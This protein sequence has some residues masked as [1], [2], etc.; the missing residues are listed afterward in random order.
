ML[1]AD[2]PTD[3]PPAAEQQREQPETPAEPPA[4]NTPTEL[5]FVNTVRQ[6]TFDL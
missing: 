1:S 5:S 4:G 3:N 2:T 6:A